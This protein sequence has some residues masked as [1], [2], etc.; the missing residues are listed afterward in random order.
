MLL[1]LFR[2][3]AIPPLCEVQTDAYVGAWQFPGKGASTNHVAIQEG[4]G[5]S[6]K[7]RK[8]PHQLFEKWLCEGG[9]W[10]KKSQFENHMVCG[11]PIKLKFNP[12]NQR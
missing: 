3:V 5:G 10:V 7:V 6:K 1:L 4:E 12:F 9:G 8:K 11:C 2:D